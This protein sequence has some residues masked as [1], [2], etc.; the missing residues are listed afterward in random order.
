MKT[1]KNCSCDLFPSLLPIRFSSRTFIRGFNG[2]AAVRGLQ[3][4]AKPTCFEFGRYE[5]AVERIQRAVEDLYMTDI[6]ILVV[7]EDCQ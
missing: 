3:I 6:L 7:V 4:S 5:D 2:V 1:H